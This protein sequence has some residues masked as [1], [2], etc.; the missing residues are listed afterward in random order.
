MVKNRAKDVPM[1][2][3]CQFLRIDII[4]RLL[5]RLNQF[6]DLNTAFKTNFDSNCH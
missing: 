6:L 4:I 2:I 1:A 5:Q 3:Y